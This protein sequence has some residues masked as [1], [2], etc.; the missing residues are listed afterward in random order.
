MKLV[1][2]RGCVGWVSRGLLWFSLLSPLGCTGPD[3][4]DAPASTHQALDERDAD[5]VARI[6]APSSRAIRFFRV[7]PHSLAG[8]ARRPIT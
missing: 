7:G 6:N 4:Q 8:P 1:R 5:A 2:N 3:P